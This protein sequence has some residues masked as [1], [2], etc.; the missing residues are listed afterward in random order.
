MKIINARIQVFRVSKPATKI[1]HFDIKPASGGIPPSPST[2][3]LKANKEMERLGYFPRSPTLSATS[4]P[5]AASDG[6]DHRSVIIRQLAARG[7]H[8][9]IVA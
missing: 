2:A 1:C 8:A 3:M 7:E 6:R 5:C 4:V 9:R